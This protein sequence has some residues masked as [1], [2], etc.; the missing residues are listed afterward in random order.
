MAPN[1]KNLNA[2]GKSILA[3][4]SAICGDVDPRTATFQ[5][6]G[7]MRG[8]DFTF[9]A[10]TID[11]TADDSDSGFRS[12]LVT[13]KTFEFT[14]DGICRFGSEADSGNSILTDLFFEEDQPM[15]WFRFTFPDRTFYVYSIINEM[16]RSAPFDDAVT[17][18]MSTMA[19]A[20]GSELPSV[21]VERTPVPAA[22]VVVTP[23]SNPIKTGATVQLTATV[24]PVATPARPVVWS[25]ADANIASVSS[26]GLVTGKAVGTTTVKA[27]V[28]LKS[29]TASVVVTA[30]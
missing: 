29:A 25:S 13:F 15:A 5:P 14:G 11:T 17:F 19:T 2:A 7:S 10:D 21:I 12:N 3:E 8:K 28:G 22:S 26:T 20:T 1:C 6:I 24:L 30:L 27:K 4:F 9:S 16:S 18:S 23:A